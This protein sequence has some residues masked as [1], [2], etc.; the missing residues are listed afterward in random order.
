MRMLSGTMSSVSANT[1]FK[2]TCGI[3]RLESR[4][5]F[6][7]AVSATL[8]PV[9]EART[10]GAQSINLDNY[11]SGTGVAANTYD[12]NTSLGVIPVQ[13]TPSITPLTVA[14]FLTY[15]NSGAYNDTVIHRLAAG[16]VWQAGG[17]NYSNGAFNTIPT[18]APVQNEFSQSNVLGT[19]AMAKLSSDPN[20]ATDQFFFNLADNSKN[21]DTQN[22]GFTVFG[23]VL[24][25][26]GLAV[27]NAIGNETTVSDPHDATGN[28]SSVPVQNGAAGITASNLL[29]INSIVPVTNAFTVSSDNP[30]V[31]SATI[32]GDALS[33]TPA[34]HGTA[35]I[36]ISA[37]GDDGST[38][39][40]TFAVT[41]PD[42]TPIAIGTGSGVRSAVYKDV[43]GSTVH[44]VLSGN[45][46]SATL[47]FDG[48]S[49]AT[50]KKGSTL[51]VN[52][53][54]LSLNQID[55]AGTSRATVLHIN[56]SGSGASIGGISSDGSVERIVAPNITLTGS[57]SI[58]NGL[59]FL[60]LGSVASG[61]TF[62]AHAFGSITFKGDVAG[63]LSSPGPIN[64]LTM[65]GKWGGSLQ[66]QFINKIH[67]KDVSANISVAAGIG[68]L[69][70][71]GTFSGNL[72]AGFL[73]KGNIRSLSGASLTMIDANADDIAK[74]NIHDST[75]STIETA[76]SMGVLNIAQPVAAT[77][78]LAGISPSSLTPPTATD[79]AA[80]I[81]TI[82]KLRIGGS[83]TANG[84]ADSSIG[85]FELMNVSIGNIVDN[86]STAAF[87]GI[88]AGR[89]VQLHASL[90]SKRF[91]IVGVSNEA[92]LK[93][94]LTK[95]GIAPTNVTLEIA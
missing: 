3:Q 34:S 50:T 93:Q 51:T 42:A 81:G 11:F 89:I 73:A 27:T 82:A 57:S 17:F 33:F 60:N 87:Y 10:A 59:F 36:T 16:F 94:R 80:G 66:V 1:G 79:A 69:N 7:A 37:S 77:Q 56:A 75:N 45:G 63:S 13:L 67:A 86:P 46:T 20:S 22:G 23:H 47:S 24:G 18:N 91:S 19:I 54:F 84:F 72:A 35:N 78:I 2:R 25:D 71:N 44:L 49:I 28:F 62:Y 43:D 70:F 53:D 52:G 41:V 4:L 9:T 8:P 85:A 88:A 12:F 32:N 92:I 68:V 39:S 6:S 26:A 76:G 40:Q 58:A 29:Y 90:N 5:L 15:V 65:H 74:L 64:I 30:S 31:V 48:G 21:L 14:N 95:Q 55:M 83:R 38:V 61:A